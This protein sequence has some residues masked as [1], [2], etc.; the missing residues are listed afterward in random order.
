MMMNLV[1]NHIYIRVIRLGSLIIATSSFRI[2]IT[3]GYQ[4]ATIECTASRGL[5]YFTTRIHTLVI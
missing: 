5:H 1:V 3:V 2:S 4:S